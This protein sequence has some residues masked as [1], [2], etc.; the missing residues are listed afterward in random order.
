VRVHY[1]DELDAVQRR[2]RE[3]PGVSAIIYDQTCAAEKRRRRK[4]GEFPDPDRRVVINER[5]CEACGD[6]GVQ[7]NC[8]AVQPVET[9]FGRKRRIDQSACNKDFSCLKGFCP[10][11]VTVHGGKVRKGSA[12]VGRSPFPVLPDPILPELTGTYGIVV[13][14]VGGTGVITIAAILGM[15]AHLEGKGVV[16]LDM[17]GLAQKG[18]AV[19]SHLKL[20]PAPGQIGSPR[21]AAGAAALVLGCDL[22]VAAGRTALPAV[23]KGVTRV[24][25]N[26][27]EVITGAFTGNPDLAF[28]GE[29]L[30]RALVDAA[31]AD[32]VDFVDATRLATRILGD[33]IAANLF[34]VGYAWQKGLVPLSGEAIER[35]IELNGVA[36]A[37]NREAFLWGRRAAHDMRA[38]EAVVRAAEPPR[39]R[40]PATPDELIEHR[41]AHLAAYQDESYAARYRATVARV[42]EAEQR[43]AP[44][45]TG[46]IEASARGLAKLMAYKDEYEV[47]RLYT[48]GA[49]RKQL[50]AEFEGG[51]RLEFHLAPPL[52][53]AKDPTTGHLRSGPS[54]LG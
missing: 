52:L 49:F 30:K 32:N 28:P 18:G 39:P 33:A 17:V 47:A 36:A 12:G 1:R 45:R 31:G 21:I 38:V 19:V 2:L 27:E 16:A 9:E 46:L 22:V 29:R 7:S 15:A 24:V 51:H 3:V 34:M 4:R 20:A 25:A 53:A 54:G 5:V 50:E 26:T 43:S 11:F 13:T 8:V 44:G 40:A 35:A 10:S 42:A 23:A 41:A 14:G 6:C 37:S 48:D